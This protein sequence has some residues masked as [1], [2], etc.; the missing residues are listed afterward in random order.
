MIAVTDD[1]VAFPVPNAHNIIRIARNYENNC[2]NHVLGYKKKPQLLGSI[3]DV[4]K[5]HLRF[6]HPVS[7]SFKE[8]K[9]ET[10]HGTVD[11]SFRNSNGYLTS[12][13]A[14]PWAKSPC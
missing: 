12:G 6:H 11:I 2:T 5:S 7:V 4:N 10:E 3:I 8:S 9:D 14:M 1:D 13:H